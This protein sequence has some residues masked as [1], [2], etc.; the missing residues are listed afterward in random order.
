MADSRDRRSRLALAAPPAALAGP[1]PPQFVRLPRR[2]RLGQ[3]SGMSRRSHSRRHVG[4]LGSFL[5]EQRE[6]WLNCNAEGCGR[7]QKMDVLA[8]IAAHGENFPLQQ[9]VERARCLKC[10]RREV[11]VTAPPNLGERGKF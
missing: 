1:D 7:S 11:N 3:H 10:G 5:T 2:G 4:T 6:L 8:L 9:L